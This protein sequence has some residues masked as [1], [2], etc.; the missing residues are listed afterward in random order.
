MNY[1]D[2]TDSPVCVNHGLKAT[3]ENIQKLLC[4]IEKLN[5]ELYTMQCKYDDLYRKHGI[6]CMKYMEDVLMRET[7]A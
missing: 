4:E 1:S 5:T 6:V 3:D 2:V 7:G